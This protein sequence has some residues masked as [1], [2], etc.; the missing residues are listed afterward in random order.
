MPEMLREAGVHT[1]LATD[2]QHYWEDGGATYHTRYNTSDLVRGQEGDAWIGQV[3]PLPAVDRVIARDDVMSRQDA[4]NRQVTSDPTQFPMN[5]TFSKG[6]EFIRRNYQADR[7]LLQIETFDPHEPFL[8]L[9]EFREPFR[10]HFDEYEGKP[11]EWP[12]YRQ[13]QESR[14]AVEH[15]R[16]EYAALVNGCDQRLGQVMDVFDEL[17]LWEDTMLIVCTDHGFLLGEHDCWA[18]CWMPFYNEIANTPFFVWDPR[19]P[20][21][22]GQRSEALVQP[23]IDLA[24]TLLSYFGLTPTANMTGHDLASVIAENGSVRDYA[25]Y[26]L[27]GAQ[28]N[29]TDGEYVYMRGP[30]SAENLPLNEYT[31][32]PT[33]MRRRF[34]PEELSQVTELA[35]PF[36]FTKGCA[37]LKV[38]STPKQSLER[39]RGGDVLATMLFD[40][41][42]DPSQIKPIQEAKTESRFRSAL[43]EEMT[44][45]DAPLEQFV[46]LGLS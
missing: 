39:G 27:F 32:M 44:R 30:V 37:T 23:M 33:R 46:R 9:D 13:V 24:P 4:A 2:H 19:A 3:E 22:A 42:A 40:L 20:H 18:K 12:P 15:A 36:S 43:V 14:E 5:V 1:H 11:L 28:V 16:Y 34:T 7:W 35:P 10:Q 6:I 25:I 45:C 29:I 26:G 21:R 38:P 41:D 31:L 8:S 17:N